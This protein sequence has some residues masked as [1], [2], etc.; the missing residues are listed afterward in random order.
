MKKAMCAWLHPAVDGND[1]WT[2]DN[3]EP[4]FVD[5]K[6]DKPSDWKSTV[7][8][9]AS[10]F[11]WKLSGYNFNTINGLADFI[12]CELV[13]DLQILKS[14]KGLINKMPS[15]AVVLGDS[16]NNPLMIIWEKPMLTCA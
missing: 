3:A 9:M 10:V 7:L 16:S 14:F 6:T 15:G 13:P 2:W 5:P 1:E 11:D 4:F 12:Q 8:E